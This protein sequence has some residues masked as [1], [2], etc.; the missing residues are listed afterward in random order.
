VA[1]A[2]TTITVTS[3]NDDD[4]ANCVLRDAISVANNGGGTVNGCTATADTAYAIVFQ[5]SLT[6]T[7]TLGSPLPLITG[8]LTIT[9]PTAAPGITISG[10]NNVQLMEVNEGATLN[11]EFLTLANGNATGAGAVDNFGTLTVNGSTFSNNQANGVIGSSDAPGETAS[12]GAI[13]NEGTLTIT[14]S[15]FSG[16]QANGG[17]AGGVFGG[18]N[19]LGGAIFDRGTGTII[20][21]TFSVNEANGGAGNSY[22][23]G[24]GFGGAIFAFSGSSPLT[25]VNSTFSGN[26][27]N[28][29]TAFGASIYN[30]DSTVNLEGTIL[31]TTSLPGNCRGAVTDNGYN[32]S[33]D[34]SCNF[35]GTSQDEVSDSLLALGTL[36]NNGGPTQTIALE[37][38]SA[39]LDYIPV[40]ACTYQLVNP[41]TNP[42]TT[43]PTGPLTC[44]QRGEQRPSPGQTACDVGAFELQQSV[45]FAQFQVGM[46]IDLPDNFLALGTL[47]PAAT[48]P[49]INPLTQAV[50][51]TL[52]SSSFGPTSLTIP[53][54]SFKKVL[55]EYVF[56]GKAGNVKVIALITSSV[57]KTYGFTISADGFDLQGITNPVTVTLQIGSDTGTKNV[58]AVIF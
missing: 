1:R 48:V 55:G 58:K 31:A 30:N 46:V 8:N 12:G 50:T 2:T 54:G 40:L 32:L 29:G 25:I 39:A 21:S 19:G 3:T 11:L 17:G 53:A 20:N 18:G 23:P 44:D 22:S 36:Q 35:S 42:P 51:L 16:N 33:D 24:N 56:T 38:G 4:A 45:P 9:G 6:G 52:S 26:Q 10:N 28:N 57:K 13:D 14:N 49:A 5:S 7:I 34:S 47:Q 27:A 37:S 41:C 15:T 43:S